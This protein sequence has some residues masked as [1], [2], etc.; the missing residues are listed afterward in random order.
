M[1]CWFRKRR[2]SDPSTRS[3]TMANVSPSATRSRIRTRCGCSQ[4]GEDGSL[5][6]KS[7]YNVSL[8]DQ[9]GP[10]QLHRNGY[11]PLSDIA[12]N[13]TWPI[14]PRPIG[15]SKT[16][17][18]PRGLGSTPST[19]FIRPEHAEFRP[20]H[21]RSPSH[22]I[23]PKQGPMDQM[24]IALRVGSRDPPPDPKRDLVQAGR[25]PLSAWIFKPNRMQSHASLGLGNP[26]RPGS[27]SP[28]DHLPSQMDVGNSSPPHQGSSLAGS[29]LPQGFGAP[30]RGCAL[31]SMFRYFASGS[32]DRCLVGSYECASL[33]TEVRGWRSRRGIFRARCRSIR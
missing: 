19:H 12:A 5:L 3:I 10:E 13:Q 29:S 9:F 14:A 1:P 25:L 21:G 27:F 33:K 20:A 2:R 7:S 4:A 18:L 26:H 24:K 11:S 28:V 6:Q 15:N 8:L 22:D 31:R 30:E 16:Y 32:V 17:A 23:V